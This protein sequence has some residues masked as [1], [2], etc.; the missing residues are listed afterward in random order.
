MCF[1]IYASHVADY[2]PMTTV[3]V[4]VQ[5][6]RFYDEFLKH[7]NHYAQ[8]SHL[9]IRKDMAQITGYFNPCLRMH[10]DKELCIRATHF[11]VDIKVYLAFEANHLKVF[12]L[13]SL[14]QDHLHKTFL[15]IKYV[16][17]SPF[18]F[19]RVTQQMAFR[20]KATW[21]AACLVP[22]LIVLLL[23]SNVISYSAAAIIL[24]FNYLVPLFVCT[25]VFKRL[26]TRDKCTALWLWPFMG[27]AMAT[28]AGAALL[29]HGYQLFRHGVRRSWNL[30]QIGMRVLART[31]KP[32]HIVHFIT[33]RCN[34]RCSHCF[35]KETLDAKDPG[36]QSLKQIEKTT[37]EIGS[38]LWY[39]IGGGEPYVRRDIVDLIKIIRKNCT[40]LMVT[41][42]TNGWYF[43]KTFMKTMEML[44]QMPNEQLTIQIS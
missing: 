7:D 35:Y 30:L 3:V 21:L 37:S 16:K 36:E 10:E 33:S 34:L 22:L 5:Q 39:A 31:G 25:E 40:P 44:Q 24:V 26:D 14:L 29:E 6:Y 8:S 18:I 11:G 9:I 20:Y 41:V 28:G 32:I 4:A 42:P 17:K 27:I 13:K 19:S 43:E 15:A 1:G 38:V 23:I 12:S 2:N